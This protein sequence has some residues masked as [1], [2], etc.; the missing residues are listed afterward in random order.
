MCV[1]DEGSAS[2]QSLASG[3]Q[4]TVGRGCEVVVAD[5]CPKVR[6]ESEKNIG[7]RAE[8]HFCL[9]ANDGET[10]LSLA[11]SPLPR[12]CHT[13]SNFRV[14]QRGED[15]LVHSSWV[16]HSYRMKKSQIYY[17]HQTHT[18]RRSGGEWKISGRYIVL[19]NDSI[20]SVLD[21]YSV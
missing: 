8:G 20:D 9:V 4:V 21:V 6:R 13:N 15:V 12:T 14:E 11:S 19:Q 2:S 17:G 16:T 1:V 3:S 10:G 18:M 5:G 7:L